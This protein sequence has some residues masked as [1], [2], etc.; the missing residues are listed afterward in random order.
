MPAHQR[1]GLNVCNDLEDRREQP[2]ELHEQP[3][4]AIGQ[5]G[6]ALSL[7][8]QDNELLSKRCVVRFKELS[9]IFGDGLKDQ[10]AAVWA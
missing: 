4:V 2:V 9:P 3:T 1:L 6:F 10:A 8:P 5:L 7:P